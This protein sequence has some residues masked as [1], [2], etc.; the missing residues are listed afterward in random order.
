MA[1]GFFLAIS[2]LSLV[3]VPIG[4]FP[5]SSMID[6]SGQFASIIETLGEIK[7]A[8]SHN[9][10]SLFSVVSAI[11]SFI[12][13]LAGLWAASSAYRATRNVQ[14]IARLEILRKLIQDGYDVISEAEQAEL[15]VREIKGQLRDL[16]R[17]TG[18]LRSPNLDGKIAEAEARYKEIVPLSEDAKKLVEDRTNLEKKSEDELSHQLSKF[19]GYLSRVRRVRVSLEK[20]AES[21]ATE[22]RI[23]QTDRIQKTP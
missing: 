20:E 9:S 21:Y 16:G 18:N 17:F 4:R 22:I 3:N 23:Y 14:R 10:F 1:R 8:L 13:A 2:L 11:G 6:Y 19:D 7:T 5:G 15:L 12:A